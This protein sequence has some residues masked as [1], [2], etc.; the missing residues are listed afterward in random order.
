MSGKTKHHDEVR[1]LKGKQKAYLRGLANNLEPLW[2]VGKGG[3]TESVINQLLDALEAR[4]LI[5]IN[6]LRNSPLETKETAEELAEKTGAELIQ[7]IG[8]KVTLYKRARKDR[9]IILPD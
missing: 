8:N 2:Q 3:V 7:V 5:K 6:V 1:W 4:E 9:K